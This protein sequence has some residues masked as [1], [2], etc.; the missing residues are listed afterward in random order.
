MSVLPAVI[1]P[2]ASAP[3]ARAAL[4]A[5]QWRQVGAGDWAWVM[6]DPGD[7]WAARV[8]PFDPGYLA[9]ARDCLT[10]EAN[11]WLPRVAEIVPLRRD[12]YIVVM[13]RLW[14]APEPAAS[15]F[16]A[17]LGITNTS[18]YAP[19]T[20]GPFEGQDHPDLDTLRGRMQALIDEGSAQHRFWACDIR[21]GNVMADAAGALKLVDPMGIAGW[22]IVAAVREGRA[23]L[24]ADLSR[25]QIED[26]LTIPYFG[27]RREGHG[28]RDELLG[29]VERLEGLS[30]G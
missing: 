23:D 4:E 19:P 26:F 14:P 5:A 10:G 28:E 22:K 16:C 25:V 3:D 12:G 21:P 1:P 24:L 20:P 8:T 27:P 7:T 2:D 17:A 15:A 29:L 9:F 30:P 13:E 18:G 11:R 6:A